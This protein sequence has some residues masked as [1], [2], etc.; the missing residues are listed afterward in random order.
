ME[1]NVPFQHKYGYIRDQVDLEKRPLNGC[2]CF[3]VGSAA[4]SKCPASCS[5]MSEATK[6]SLFMENAAVVFIS[7]DV[8]D[9]RVTLLIW[10]LSQIYSLM[11][12]GSV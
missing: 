9:F 1:F 10:M 8:V 5:L 2:L 4:V 6:Q 12:A 7:C 11:I 3:A